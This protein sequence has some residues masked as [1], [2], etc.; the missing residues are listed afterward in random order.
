MSKTLLVASLATAALITMPTA[1]L[2]QGTCSS[3]LKSCV[4]QG[5]NVKGGCDA[6]FKYCMKN[7]RWVWQGSGETGRDWGAR[8]KK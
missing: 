6:T 1:S 2:A 8:E 5:N 4:Q 7:G 3:M